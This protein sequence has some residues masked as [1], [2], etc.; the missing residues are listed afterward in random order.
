MKILDPF[1]THIQIKR[2]FVVLKIIDP[3]PTW[4]N[5]LALAHPYTP[6]FSY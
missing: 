6:P 1:M 4:M 5:L 3:P 2:F